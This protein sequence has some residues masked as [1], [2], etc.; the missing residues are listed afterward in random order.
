MALR[1]LGW[2]EEA[3]ALAGVRAEQLPALVP[4]TAQPGRLTASAAAELG[5]SRDT[6]VVIGAGDGP[7]ANL[8]VGAV[9]PGVAACSIGTSGALRLVVDRPVVDRAGRLF[10]YALTPGRW[11]VGGAINNGGLVLQW[12]GGSRPTS[13]R[14]PR[15]SCSSSP[16]GS[17]RAARAC[18]CCRP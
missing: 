6:P 11:V 18:S 9:R 7:L 15:P 2:D 16:P 13:G 1:T 5:L 10:C 4:T 8:G 12:A 3:L 14:T 17:R